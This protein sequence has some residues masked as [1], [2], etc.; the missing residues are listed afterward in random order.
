MGML[1]GKMKGSTKGDLP[2][3]SMTNKLHSFT[4]IAVNSKEFA[5]FLMML[6]VGCPTVT[7]GLSS[8][9]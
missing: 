9:T 8:I 7:L 2:T 3:K 6:V 1:L 5:V 4:L